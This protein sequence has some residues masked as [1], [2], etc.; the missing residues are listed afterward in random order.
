MKKPASIFRFRRGS[1]G[2]VMS[3]HPA[4]LIIGI[5]EAT[6]TGQSHTQAHVS[7]TQPDCACHGIAFV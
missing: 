3:W 7:E 6:L 4:E 2:L 5:A 1:A